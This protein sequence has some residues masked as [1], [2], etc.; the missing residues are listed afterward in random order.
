MA[1]SL[2]VHNPSIFQVVCI[3]HLERS[4]EECRVA[5]RRR[6]HDHCA[7]M[8]VPVLEMTASEYRRAHTRAMDVPSA[9][10]ISSYGRVRDTRLRSGSMHAL[11]SSPHGPL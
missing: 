6:R 5:R 8:G 9:T 2:A 4:I 3:D 10:P 11:R 1:L 7:G